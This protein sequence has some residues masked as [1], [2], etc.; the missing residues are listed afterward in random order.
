MVMWRAAEGDIPFWQKLIEQ[1][2]K[3]LPIIDARMTRF[4]IILEQAVQF[5]RNCFL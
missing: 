4:W 2:I 5:V 3:A 1:G